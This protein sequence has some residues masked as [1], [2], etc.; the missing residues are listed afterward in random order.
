MRFRQ[1]F[2]AFTL[3]L[4]AARRAVY[5]VALLIALLGIIRLFQ[6]FAPVAVP[7]GIPFFRSRSSCPCGRTAM[8]GKDDPRIP[9]HVIA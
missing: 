5:F 6:G 4:P 2:I 9:L 3:K 1:V 7:L 8:R